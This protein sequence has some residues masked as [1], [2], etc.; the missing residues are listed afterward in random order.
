MAG[1]GAAWGIELGS[2]AIKAIKLVATGDG[3]EVAEIAHI[4]HTKVLSTPELDVD[5][6]M[7][8]AIGQLASNY[9][10][11]KASVA[12]GLPG[13]Q[14]FAR[15][16]KLPPVEPKK[17][18]DIVKFEAMQQIPFPLE[19]VEWDYQTF[20]SDDSPEIEVGIFAVTRERVGQ[21]IKLLK[22]VNIIPDVVML[23]P[24]AAYNALAYDLGFTEKTP[25][26]VILDV[27][28]NS[29]DL[30][31]AEAGRVWVRT[32]PLGG[33]QFT[34]ALVNAF[35]LSYTKADRLK[36]EA[37]RSKHARHVFQAMKGVFADLAQ[38]TQRSIGYYQ[39]LHPEAELTRVIG[40][41]STF[42]LPGLRR[43][44][45]QQLQL[46]VYRI[47][48]LK[49]AKVEGPAESDVAAVALELMPAYGLA[50][51]GLGLNTIQANLMPVSAL[52]DAVWSRKTK[53]FGLAAGLAVAA[54]GAM[55]IG[56]AR[57][58]VNAPTRSPVIQSVNRTLSTFRTEAQDAGVTEAGADT[59]RAAQLMELAEDRGVYA[60]LTADLADLMQH[61]DIR[62]PEWHAVHGDGPRRGFRFISFQT[63]YVPAAGA[64]ASAGA[65]RGFGQPEEVAKDPAAQ[66][67]RITIELQV[68]T[69]QPAARD[70]VLETVRPWLVRN[71]ERDGI[72]Y[73]FMGMAPELDFTDLSGAA[74]APG[75][76]GGFAR[77][78]R[79]TRGERGQ[80]FETRDSI[81]RGGQPDPRTLG[82]R[83]TATQPRAVTGADV[84]AIAPLPAPPI[85]DANEEVYVIRWSAVFLPEEPIT[86]EGDR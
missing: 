20:A 24:V 26:T 56:F 84:D 1:S 28:T 33:H 42:H 3:V 65:G 46:E 85:S 61:A 68:A 37:E 34:E 45:K 67:P 41:G 57:D 51:Q 10:L 63:D 29:T 48:E 19:E 30:I 17:V 81:G 73:T 74:A 15:F 82:T 31:I 49:R 83:G 32:F 64:D 58:T 55:F 54:G 8:V 59:T 5:A 71:A 43:F 75:G 40:T 6:A 76:R 18:P 72:P 69:G 80:P 52:R 14:S 27:G 7:R 23:N 79:T 21:Q 53:W 4:P 66:H 86:Q 77:T 36:R 35:K 47:D 44:L 78:D 16:A 13:N 12:V 25:G 38:E 2:G 9:D 62:V 60:M 22:E 50:L 39:S 11:S 70:F